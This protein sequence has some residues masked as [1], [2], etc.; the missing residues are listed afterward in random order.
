M[1]GC[2]NMIAQ[3]ERD[4]N[5]LGAELDAA[6]AQCDASE[7]RRE[8]YKR[9]AHAYRCYHS[10]V[11]DLVAQCRRFGIANDPDLRAFTFAYI[12][13]DPYFYR[14]GYIMESLLPGVKSLS[15]TLNERNIIRRAIL[16]RIETRA[17]RNFR[18]LCRLIRFVDNAQFRVNLS[19]RANSSDPQICRRAKFALV[20]LPE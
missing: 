10:P 18:H 9:A 4:K 1:Q 16:K 7:G 12:K 5:A 14:S 6:F 15:L 3:C 13:A 20:Y 11:Y 17:L 8:N 19:A 2:V